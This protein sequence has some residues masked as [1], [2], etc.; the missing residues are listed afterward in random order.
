MEWST[1]EI[2]LFWLCFDASSPDSLSRSLPRA[3]YFLKRWI[4][5]GLCKNLYNKIRYEKW[6]CFFFLFL[7]LYLLM[8]WMYKQLWKQFNLWIRSVKMVEKWRADFHRQG[9][10]QTIY[11]YFEKPSPDFD[12]CLVFLSVWTNDKRRFFSVWRFRQCH[13]D[14]CYVTRFNRPN[15]QLVNICATK[16]ITYK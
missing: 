2:C 5:F 3:V 4:C 16:F 1:T 10:P 7:S 8:R 12:C 13:N 9:E 15:F 11:M 14:Y 6:N